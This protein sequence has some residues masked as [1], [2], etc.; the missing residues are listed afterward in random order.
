MDFIC[1][2]TPDVN[3]WH[4]DT[5]NSYDTPQNLGSISHE[6]VRCSFYCTYT[7]S[8]GTPASRRIIITE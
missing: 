8:G 6:W 2:D 4:F 5:S 7:A 3:N 1:D